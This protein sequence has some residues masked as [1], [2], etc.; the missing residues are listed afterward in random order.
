MLRF[1][2]TGGSQGIGAALVEQARGA[3]HDVVFTGRNERLI[4]GLAQA[5]GARGVVADVSNGH[6]NERTVAECREIAAKGQRAFPQ[7]CRSPRNATLSGH[8]STMP[9]RTA[10]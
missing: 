10:C 3:G 5:T 6:D 9:S 8:S 2:I 1:L 4:G 7:S